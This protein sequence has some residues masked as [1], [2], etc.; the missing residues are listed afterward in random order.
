MRLVDFHLESNITLPEPTTAAAVVLLEGAFVAPDATLEKLSQLQALTRLDVIGATGK[1]TRK[2]KRYWCN[3]LA[4]IS[5]WSPRAMPLAAADVTESILR[6]IGLVGQ[7]TPLYQQ[8]FV[9]GYSQGA[10]MAIL[11]QMAA[12]ERIRRVIAACP[13]TVEGMPFH[14]AQGTEIDVIFPQDDCFSDQPMREEISRA[15]AVSPLIIPHHTHAWSDQLVAAIA[16][17]ITSSQP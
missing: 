2:Q 1:N 5:N 15:L 6:I 10:I 17:K 13:G 12:P 3:I 7:L 16:A 11:A 14:R 9:V 8:I 4:D